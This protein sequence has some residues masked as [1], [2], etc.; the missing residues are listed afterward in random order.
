MA[1]VAARADVAGRSEPGAW[2]RRKT[3][4]RVIESLVYDA[5]RA[6][7]VQYSGRSGVRTLEDARRRKLRWSKWLCRP[8]S[9]PLIPHCV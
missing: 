1:G 4:F 8:V 7:Y 2:L 3:G 5:L 6:E 9:A